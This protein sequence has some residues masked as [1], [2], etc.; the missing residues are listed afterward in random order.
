MIL[1]L[2]T[3]RGWALLLQ[4]GKPEFAYAKSNQPQHKFRIVSSQP[5]PPGD[6]VVLFSFKYDGGGIGKGGDGTLFV[7]GK[8]VAQG[9]IPETI[10]VRFSLD[11]TLDIGEDTGTPVIETYVDK[12]PFRFTGT[13]KKVVV[14]LEPEKLSDEERARLRA[15]EARGAA[16]I[17]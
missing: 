12:M 10:P 8:Q 2:N 9:R 14:V 11:E 15:E 13:L 4:D 5:L 6:H 1:V 7:D 16:A 17:H 3:C